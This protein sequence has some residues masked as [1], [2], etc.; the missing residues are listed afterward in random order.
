VVETAVGAVNKT[1]GVGDGEGV[2]DSE[3]YLKCDILDR[4]EE[5]KGEDLAGVGGG[6]SKLES[7]LAALVGACGVT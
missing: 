7:E 5:D 1:G 3:R 4:R 6:A 2:R